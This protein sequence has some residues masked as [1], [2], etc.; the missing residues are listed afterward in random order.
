M[1]RQNYRGDFIVAQTF[2]RDVD[3]DGVSSKKQVSVPDHVIVEFFTKPGSGVYAVERDGEMMKNCS[4]SSD[5][6]TLFCNLALSR[7]NIGMGV[8]YRN[9]V[10]V[11]EDKSFPGNKRYVPSPEPLEIILHPGASDNTDTIISET[12][13]ASLRYGYSA[14]QLAVLHGYK[15]TEDEWVDSLNPQITVDENGNLC[16]GGVIVYSV[17]AAQVE[18]VEAIAENVV[19]KGTGD[20]ITV[21]SILSDT[22]TNPVENRAINTAFAGKQDVL[23]SGESIKTINGESVLGAGDI[24]IAGGDG[25]VI[26]DSALDISSKNPVTNAAI[27]NAINLKQDSLTFDS[28]PV[29]GSSNPVTSDGIASAFDALASSM[30][31]RCTALDE[32]ID[33]VDNKF[34]VRIDVKLS[35]EE[36]NIPANG[37]NVEYIYVFTTDEDTT[38]AITADDGVKWLNGTEPSYSPGSAVIVS[39]VNN[40]AVWGKF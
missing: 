21:D 14:Y 22:S 29:S 24:E 37:T 13:L 11:N 8:L 31:A 33:Q 25:S 17:S 27:T 32:R 30:D 9:T 2:Y 7:K 36:Y 4:V 39:V 38:A 28:S 18:E 40:F 1:I 16:V 35:D 23:V 26:V 10:E 6:M 34:P 3:V 15:G 5:G 20:K 19:I 12:I